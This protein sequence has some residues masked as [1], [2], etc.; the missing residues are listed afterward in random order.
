MTSCMF[1]A[2]SQ[3]FAND[4]ISEGILY[5]YVNCRFVVNKECVNIDRLRLF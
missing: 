4:V 5:D 2:K 3:V 1:V